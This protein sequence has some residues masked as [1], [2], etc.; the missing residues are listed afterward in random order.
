MDACAAPCPFGSEDSSQV[1]DERQQRMILS[2]T[3]LP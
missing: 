2:T 1:D 3:L